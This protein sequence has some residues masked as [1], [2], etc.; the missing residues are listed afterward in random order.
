MSMLLKTLLIYCAAYSFSW[1]SA[2]I[3]GGSNPNYTFTGGE[4]EGTNGLLVVPLSENTYSLTSNLTYRRIGGSILTA[5]LMIQDGTLDM[6][7]YTSEP[8]IILDGLS[9]EPEEINPVTLIINVSSADMGPQLLDEH[10]T[11]RVTSTL[12]TRGL[13]IGPNPE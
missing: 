7:T 13:I 10:C 6:A 5:D 4:V 8:P 2:G 11:L 9:G 12:S 3:L 1:S